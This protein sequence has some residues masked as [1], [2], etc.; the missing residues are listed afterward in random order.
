M[1]CLCNMVV[2]CYMLYTTCFNPNIFFLLVSALFFLSG[3]TY[4]SKQIT[5]Y[6]LLLF[7]LSGLLLLELL[8]LLCHLNIHTSVVSYFVSMLF[9]SVFGV[10]E[11]KRG[12]HNKQVKFVFSSKRLFRVNFS[13]LLGKGFQRYFLLDMCFIV[14]VHNSQTFKQLLSTF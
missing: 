5:C 6:C 4:Q 2:C 14:L 13:I 11:V 9:N 3:Q 8:L 7:L 10:M 12:W 1:L